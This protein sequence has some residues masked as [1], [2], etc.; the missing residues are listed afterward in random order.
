MQ[1]TVIS[2]THEQHEGIGPLSGEVLIHCGDMLNMFSYD[3]EALDKLDAW[4]GEQDF[5]LVLCIG[6]NHDDDV[7]KRAGYGVP[8]LRNAHY[9]QDSSYVYK[10]VTFYGAPWVPELY[11]QAFFRDDD[12]L[13][14]HWSGIPDD[15]D[16]LITHTPPAGV[17][18][19]N[20]RGRSLGCPMLMESIERVEPKLHCFGHVHASSGT[21]QVGAT[22]FVNAAMVGS[23]Y[24]LVGKPRV[25][26][27]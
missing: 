10:G 2:D 15:V 7:E 3:D 20:S 17:L 14:D 21:Q 1:L 23:R 22:R 16:V 11:G 5:D 25:V 13:E 4:F 26:N 24:Q 8:P 19:T 6:G 12:D 9:L 18:D 27:I